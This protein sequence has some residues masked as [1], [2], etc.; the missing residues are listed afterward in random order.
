MKRI[1]LAAA[2]VAATALSAHAQLNLS[3]LANVDISGLSDATFAPAFGNNPSAVA[4][5]GTTAWVGG[6]NTSGVAANTGWARVD[7]VLTT[8]ALP[9]AVGQIYGQV[10]TPGSR[11]ITGAVVSGNSLFV[12]LD[13]GAA[14]TN[15][16]RGFNA[17]TGAQLWDASASGNAGQRGSAVGLNTG[18]AGGGVTANSPT[19]LG[20]GSGFAR[21][22][23]ASTGTSVNN[24][25]VN[26]SAGGTSWRD[27]GFDS[28]G[29]M[30]IRESNRLIF[31]ARTG[32][33]TITAPS[34]VLPTGL[35]V[36]SAVDNQNLAVLQPAFGNF[37]LLNDRTATAAG[38]LMSNAVKAFSFAGTAQTLTFSGFDPTTVTGTGAYDFAYNSAT[39]TVAIS[40]FSNRRLYVFNVTAP[41]AVVP[42]AGTMSL[43]ALG[44]ATLGGM[45]IKKRKA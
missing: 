37:V 6:Y 31:A 33:A 34:S 27:L 43:L 44:F 36:A 8:P 25:N 40:D 4:W 32:D 19:F 41:V 12:G 10:S 45:I 22:V 14:S 17:T 35:V 38:Q 2:M 24:I 7:S 15:S 42:E 11:G 21:T 30:F 5:D 26:S 13:T 9:T 3:L 16:Y 1:L 29:N 20:I 39:N 23:N 28:S 18:F